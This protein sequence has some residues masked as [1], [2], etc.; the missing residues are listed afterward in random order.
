MTTARG[1]NRSESPP[2][3]MLLNAMARKPMVIALDTPVTD[4]PV[5][6]AIGCKRTGNENIDPMAMQPKRPPAATITQRSRDSVITH[7]TN[8]LVF[9]SRDP[10]KRA[11]SV[12]QSSLQLQSPR[13][14][15]PR[16]GLEGRSRRRKS[17]N[18]LDHPSRRDAPHRP[19]DEVIGFDVGPRSRI[20]PPARSRHASNVGPSR[21]KPRLA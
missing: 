12:R 5:S 20:I 1:P 21:R 13:P 4:Q 14:E 16:C 9:Q 8:W 2:H 10:P 7:H 18:E 15:A 6:R 11:F 17:W 3:A 19:Q